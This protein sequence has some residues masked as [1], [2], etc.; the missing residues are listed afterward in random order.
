MCEFIRITCVY[1]YVVKIT[2]YEIFLK[3]DVK[4]SE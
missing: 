1:D 2:K 3:G 4:K